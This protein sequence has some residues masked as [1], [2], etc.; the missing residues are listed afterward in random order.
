MIPLARRAYARYVRLSPAF[1]KQV[2]V[3]K[4]SNAPSPTLALK[5]GIGGPRQDILS[6]LDD[7]N[8]QQGSK[9]PNPLNP[10]PNAPLDDNPLFAPLNY[11]SRPTAKPV[12][13]LLT[14]RLNYAPLK[15]PV[16]TQAGALPVGHP[17]AKPAPVRPDQARLLS[18]AT[19]AIPAP[20]PHP[21]QWA[22]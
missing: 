22:A 5:P 7:Y 14:N 4:P 12:F 10:S 8:R 19:K 2:E 9:R 13:S 1:S 11:A 21:G 15:T 6:I 18:L 3:K 17:S 16:A 20:Y